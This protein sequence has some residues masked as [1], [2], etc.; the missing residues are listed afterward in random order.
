MI[1]ADLTS[2]R[3]QDIRVNTVCR[4][5]PRL[6]DCVGGGR[7]LKRFMFGMRSLLRKVEGSQVETNQDGGNTDRFDFLKDTHL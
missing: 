5:D 7:V 1:V 6:L 2:L 3:S 4:S